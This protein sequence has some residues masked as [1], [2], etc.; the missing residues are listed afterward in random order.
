M[1]QAL[2]ATRPDSAKSGILDK[3]KRQAELLKWNLRGK[4]VPPPHSIKVAVISAIAQRFDCK[5]LVETGTFLGDMVARTRHLFERVYTIEVDQTLHARAV[6][7]FQEDPCVSVLHGDS[8]HVLPKILD[9]LTGPAVFWLDG[10]Y[11]GGSTGKGD[12]ET[13]VQ[14]EVELILRHPIGGHAILVDDA[15]LFD[16]TGDYPTLHDFRTQLEKLNRNYQFTVEHDMIRY[17]PPA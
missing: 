10:H 8:A 1:A 17:L 13:P 11:S 12:L 16:G 9:Q 7:R 4:P 6:A 15:R 5:T 2:T 3:F 14:T